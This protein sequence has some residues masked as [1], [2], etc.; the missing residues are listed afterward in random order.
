MEI[1][2]KIVILIADKCS[3]HDIKQLFFTLVV[4]LPDYCFYL[5]KPVLNRIQLG[6]IRR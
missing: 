1:V 2:T 5:A 3:M 6:R 4:N